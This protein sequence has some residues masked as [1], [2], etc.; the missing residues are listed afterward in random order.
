MRCLGWAAA[1]I[2]ALA[3]GCDRI[4]DLTLR[5]PDARSSIDGAFFDDGGIAFDD[6]GFAPDAPPGDA[7]FRVDALARGDAPPPPDALP[8]ADALPPPDALPLADVPPSPEAVPPPDARRCQAPARPT[9]RADRAATGH[10]AP[11]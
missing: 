5:A 10:C 4:V 3:S 6:G 7:L 2:A 1:L 9:P 8:L 11:R